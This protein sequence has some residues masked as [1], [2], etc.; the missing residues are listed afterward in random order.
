MPSAAPHRVAV[1]VP[2]FQRSP[3]LLAKALRAVMAQELP[4]GTTWQAIVVDDSSPHPATAEL[5]SLPAAITDRVTLLRQ[6]NAGP[7]GARNRALDHVAATGGFDIVAFLDSDDTWAPTHLAEAL[8]ALDRGHDLYFCNHHRFEDAET[9]FEI[10]PELAAL[11]RD[12]V[13]GLTLIDPDGP[14]HALT[15]EAFMTAQLGTYPSQTST[16]VLR[17]ETLGHHR[18][19]PDMRSAGEDHLFWVAL[20]ADRP[21]VAVSLR[22]NVACGRGVNVYFNALDWGSTRVVE[23]VGDVLLFHHKARA[24]VRR[25][26]DRRLLRARIRHYERG[27]SFHFLRALLCGRLPSLRQFARLA[28]HSPALPLWLPGRFLRV[29]VDRRPGARFW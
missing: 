16:V 14:V 10:V 27:Y 8:A 6:P 17:S 23:R 18:F 29:L 7:G 9:Y 28:R 15:P 19:D 25:P 26:A 4:S 2:Y 13:P 20:A 24:L 11:F 22:S 21:R 1:I 5:A 12:G 3:G